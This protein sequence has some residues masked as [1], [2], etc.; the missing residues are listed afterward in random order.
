MGPFTST[1]FM[2]F[3]RLDAFYN[4]KTQRVP[5]FLS[6]MMFTDSFFLFVKLGKPLSIE[7]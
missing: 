5:G 1:G 7:V 2:F 6:G 4:N 3:K